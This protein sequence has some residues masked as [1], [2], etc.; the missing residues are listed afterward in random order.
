VDNAVTWN[1]LSPRVGVS[2]ALDADRKTVVRA[3]YASFASQLQVATSGTIAANS[4][5]YAYYIG[6]DGNSN[7]R[8]ERE[9]IEPGAIGS[10]GID[11]DN[12]TVSVNAIDPDL[13]APR[14][15]EIVFG[16]DHELMRN[17]AISGSFTW[18]RFNDPIWGVDGGEPFPVIGATTADYLLDGRVSGNTEQ[19]G[20]YDV[21]YYALDPAVAPVGGGTITRNRPGY[22]RSF[23]GFELAATKRL[24]DRWMARFGFSWNDEREHFT[25][26]SLS[27]QDPTPIRQAPLVDGGAVIR[28]TS[29]SGKSQVYLIVPKYQ[30]IANGFWQGPWDVGIGANL[31]TRQ[32]YGKPYHVND[33]LTNDPVRAFKDVLV[34]SDLDANRLP[35]VT[36]F[37]LR[38]Q[39]LLRLRQS[40]IEFDVDIF[41]LFNAATVLGRQ[42]DVEATGTRG[43]DSVLEIM[44][45]RIVR[46]GMRVKF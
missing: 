14:S 27:I 32:G 1:S 31:V 8:I 26:P 36:S 19:T 24:A 22:H 9:E 33:V 34:V 29:G 35:A 23:Q 11:P 38:F 6:I 17:F 42:Y 15:H 12:P 20:A 40:N 7:G 21:P 18:R 4:Y 28:P 44:N 41:N 30:F 3:S 37:D 2:Y 43:F 25:D 10:V 16:A 39:K 5:G 13:T 46:L 45:P